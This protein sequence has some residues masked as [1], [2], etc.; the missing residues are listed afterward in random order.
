[1]TRRSLCYHL[2]LN[3]VACGYY[4]TARIVRM[5]L[6]CFIVCT[7][8]ARGKNATMCYFD[9]STGEA[10]GVV[11]LGVVTTIRSSPGKKNKNKKGHVLYVARYCILVVY[12]RGGVICAALC[13]WSWHCST[14]QASPYCCHTVVELLTNKRKVNPRLSSCLAW[15][16]L[17]FGC[18]YC[19][20]LRIKIL[21]FL[22]HR[23]LRHPVE[24]SECTYCSRHRQFNTVQ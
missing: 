15:R 5:V 19:C 1:M 21:S 6:V 18:C 11:V 3:C 13:V 7:C 9:E 16:T 22:L 2:L 10:G 14:Q 17:L 12:H 23:T 4:S 24:Y 8:T 20:C